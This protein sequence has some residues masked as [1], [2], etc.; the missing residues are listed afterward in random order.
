MKKNKEVMTR[1][2]YK[3]KK[4][5]N[6]VWVKAKKI[7]IIF[8]IGFMC[9][10]VY[11]NLFICSDLIAKAETNE[12]KEV[13]QIDQEEEKSLKTQKNAE[14]ESLEKIEELSNECNLDE[15]SCKIKKIA[16][17]YGVDWRL[18]IAISKHETW[19][20]TSYI[21][22][23]QNN[24]GG[25]WNGIKGEFYSYETLDAGIEAYISN[26]KH[27]YY[28]EGRTTI[29]TIQPKYAPIG[30]NNDPNDLNSNWIPGVNRRYK[31]LGGK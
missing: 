6:K 4:E 10:L 8:F 27:N 23:H 22:K 26:L 31:E 15:V 11:S 1:K 5:I 2:G 7:L 19:D 3:R 30:A 13:I 9:G 12:S 28:D 21:F 20:Y 17:D 14:L 18:A 25:L 29:E 24:V 16:Q